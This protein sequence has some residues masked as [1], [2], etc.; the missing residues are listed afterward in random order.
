[1]QEKIDF[2]GD[3][4]PQT[5]QVMVAGEKFRFDFCTNNQD[6]NVSNVEVIIKV[7]K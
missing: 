4:A 1:M 5:K 2:E 6:V 3:F 7:D